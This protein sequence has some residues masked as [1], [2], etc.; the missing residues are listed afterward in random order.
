MRTLLISA[1]IFLATAAQSQ[2]V[3]LTAFGDAAGI[4]GF[5]QHGEW[6]AG[7]VA[8]QLQGVERLKSDVNFVNVEASLT[9][10]CQ[11][12]MQKSFPFSM[13]PKTLH[14]FGDST[15]LGWP[16]TTP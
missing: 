13:G 9:R 6:P 3:T 5:G 4:R 15:F 8:R 7:Q 11:R 12:Y 16:I 2:T 14:Q 1:G 10:S